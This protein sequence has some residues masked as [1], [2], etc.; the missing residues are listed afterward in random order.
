MSDLREG[1]RLGFTDEVVTYEASKDDV[2]ASIKKKFS[3]EFM[4]WIDSFVYFNSLTPKDCI[5]IAKLSLQD[6]PIKRY[7]ALLTYIVEHGYSKEYGARN[8]K[9]FVKM[10]VLISYFVLFAVF[11]SA[12][13]ALVRV[14]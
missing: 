13:W 10:D 8:I 12:I 4:N 9:R 5:K 1:K 14:L 7:K 2:K 3:P 6:L 11:V